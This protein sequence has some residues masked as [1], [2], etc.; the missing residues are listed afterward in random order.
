MKRRYTYTSLEI[1]W[2][3]RVTPISISPMSEMQPVKT[4]QQLL[5]GAS[6][7]ALIRMISIIQWFPAAGISI[8]LSKTGI[9]EPYVKWERFPYQARWYLPC[10]VQMERHRLSLYWT[11]LSM[12]FLKRHNESSDLIQTLGYL[13]LIVECLDLQIFEQHQV[14]HQQT[15]SVFDPWHY[16]ACGIW[17][18]GEHQ[19]S[20]NR[21]GKE[22]SGIIWA[23]GS[24]YPLLY[25]LDSL[26]D[27]YE[28]RTWLWI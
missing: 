23:S 20:R 25:A 15:M 28:M 6:K 2:Q 27:Q 26:T 19:R 3:D 7:L 21:G 9:K 22:T 4:P 10:R 12:D 8:S 11:P 16:C 14:P 24:N 17:N 18:T 1:P 13:A 5:S